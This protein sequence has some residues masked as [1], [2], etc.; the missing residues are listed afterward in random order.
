MAQIVVSIVSAE[1]QE[2]S[3]VPTLL[4]YCCHINPTTPFQI[5]TTALECVSTLCD[6][7][8]QLVKHIEDLNSDQWEQ[9][10]A[11]CSA[12]GQPS[13]RQRASPAGTALLT[14]WPRAGPVW[15]GA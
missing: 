10:H 6:Q 8:T 7:A 14:D 5:L 1:R 4:Y 13:A 3:P 15:L 9:L 12:G 2:V 11:W